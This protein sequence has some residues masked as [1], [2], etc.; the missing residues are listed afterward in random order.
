MA[1]VLYMLLYEKLNQFLLKMQLHEKK[2]ALSKMISPQYASC[3]REFLGI[4]CHFFP[5]KSPQPHHISDRPCHD[6]ED[7]RGS[8]RGLHGLGQLEERRPP[9]FTAA[10]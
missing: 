1:L 4:R 6:Q 8:L 2:N 10:I 7:Y 9:I 5:V 3:T